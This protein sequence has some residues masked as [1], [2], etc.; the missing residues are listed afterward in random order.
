MD[1]LARYS[2]PFYIFYGICSFL[3]FF[4]YFF[5]DGSF[6]VSFFGALIASTI[7]LIISALFIL[8]VLFVVLS[9]LSY[10]ISFLFGLFKR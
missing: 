3:G 6:V 8:P 4:A 2:L 9:L 1:Y 7:F 10:P 5:Q